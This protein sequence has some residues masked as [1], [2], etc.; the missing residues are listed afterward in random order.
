MDMMYIKD[1]RFGKILFKSE[2]FH[3]GG[4]FVTKH[5]NMKPLSMLALRVTG[6]GEYQMLSFYIYDQRR[7]GYFY[8]S[9]HAMKIRGRVAKTLGGLNPESCA[10]RIR[11]ATVHRAAFF[12]LD[13]RDRRKVF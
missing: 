8:V 6:K 9:V 10:N 1:N 4:H 11:A 5:T 12:G 3:T 2:I 7:Q 13:W